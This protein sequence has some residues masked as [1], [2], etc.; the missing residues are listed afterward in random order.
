MCSTSPSPVPPVRRGPGVVACAFYRDGQPRATDNRNY[1]PGVLRLNLAPIGSVIPKNPGSSTVF[2]SLE[3]QVGYRHCHA[4]ILHYKKCRSGD[5]AVS[6][7][8]TTD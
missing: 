3:R 6:N 2:K 1:Q 7:H 8:A 4:A 5:G